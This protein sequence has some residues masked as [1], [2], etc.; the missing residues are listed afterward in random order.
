MKIR[1]DDPSGGELL[2]GALL[3]LSGFLFI[4]ELADIFADR[5]AGPILT[6]ASR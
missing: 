1:A 2:G 4:S 5:R 3:F 6:W